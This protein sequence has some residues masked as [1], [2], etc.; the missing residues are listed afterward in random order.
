MFRLLFESSSGPQDVDPDIQKFSELWDP[1]FLQNKICA[2]Y[3]YI[4]KISVLMVYRYIKTEI[5]KVVVLTGVI[6]YKS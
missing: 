5:V 4:Y 2:L 3:I 6:Y 1:Q